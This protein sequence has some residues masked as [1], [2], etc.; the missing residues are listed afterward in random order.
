MPFVSR[1]P[2]PRVQRTRSSPSARHEPL[3]RCPLGSAIRVLLA[4]T[5]ILVSSPQVSAKRH[6]SYVPPPYLERVARAALGLLPL[7]ITC[8]GACLAVARKASADRQ[9]R[10]IVGAVLLTLAGAAVAALD[11]WND[12]LWNPAFWGSPFIAAI[13]L[14]SVLLLWRTVAVWKRV[15]VGVLLAPILAIGLWLLGDEWQNW[16]YLRGWPVSW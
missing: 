16:G 8:T 10:L 6:P 4:A 11:N 14:L 5:A 13:P 3:T 7:S 15:A 12:E 1:G 2:N 9:K